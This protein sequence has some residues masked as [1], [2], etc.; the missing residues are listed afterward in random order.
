MNK[1]Y[2]KTLGIKSDNLGYLN[3]VK[4]SPHWWEGTGDEFMPTSENNDRNVPLKSVGTR[5]TNQIPK[6]RFP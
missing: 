6:T 5:N 2:I 4:D 3:A 1:Q